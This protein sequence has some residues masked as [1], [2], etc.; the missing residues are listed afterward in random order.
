MDEFVGKVALITGAGRGLGR[1]ISMA[2]SSLGVAV[3][4]NDINPIN[5]DETVNLI[6]QAGGSAR[7]YV[8]DIAKRMPIEGMVA[9]VLDQFGRIDILVNHASVEPDAFIL[10]MDEWEFH[11]TLDVNLGGPFFC[12]QQVGRAMRAHGGGAMVNIASPIWKRKPHKRSAAHLASQAG[13]LGLTRAAAQ[14][15]SPYKIRVNAVCTGEIEESL[16]TS[17]E[18][19][20]NTLHQWLGTFPGVGLGHHPELVSLVLFLCS[21]AA[22]SL[23]GQV[24]SLN[25]GN[26]GRY[27]E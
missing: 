6:L 9:Q 14:E 15:F 22:S 25:L 19:N 21:E 27:P 10:D 2:L 1:E 26:K 18:W 23:T 12:M 11:R 4:A 24:I 13:M 8:F 7:V 3:A 17:L 20:I 5:L 16:F